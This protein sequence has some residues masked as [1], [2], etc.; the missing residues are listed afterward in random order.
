MHQRLL[1]LSSLVLILASCQ[2]ELDVPDIFK[3]P[4]ITA[5][6]Q[7]ETRTVLSV[8]EYGA[9]TIYWKPS[10]KIDVFIGDTKL[11]YTS[12][13]SSNAATAT[14]K[15]ND[16]MGYNHPETDPIVAVYPSY[17]DSYYNQD[18]A[19][20]TSLPTTQYGVPGT[21]DD[22]LYIAVATGT[23][24]NLGSNTPLSFHN[25]CSGLKFSL[26]RDDITCV[27]LRGTDYSSG[28][29]V[30][31]AGDVWLDSDGSLIG[32][33]ETT[34]SI[35]PKTGDTF[36]KDANYYI[37]CLPATLLDFYV[38]FETVSGS[39]ATLRGSDYN[40]AR[41]SDYVD[42]PF[43]FRPSVFM[44]K[45]HI[46]EYA[47]FSDEDVPHTV[48]KYWTTGN[49]API[50]QNAPEG[51]WN[52]WFGADS[53]D[54]A[55]SY[56][57]DGGY[58]EIRF[59]SPVTCVAANMFKNSN[60][61]RIY[62]PNSVTEIGD[63]AFDGCKQL[64]YLPVPKSMATIGSWAFHDCS[65]L[66]SS[67]FYLS[68]EVT[69]IGSGAFWG[70]SSLT[71]FRLP[72]SVTSVGD[73]LFTACSKLTTIIVA[74]GNPVYDSRDNCNAI[75]ETSSD[76]L[77]AGCKGTIIPNSVKTIGQSAFA[78]CYG[79]ST[80]MIPTSVTEI[81]PN[82][83]NSCINFTSI[84]IPGSVKLIDVGAFA[85]CRSLTS[86][87]IPSSV[88]SIGF[89]AFGECT[90]LTSI[91]LYSPTPP[92]ME[93]GAFDNTNDCPIYVP[94]GSVDA[95]K[96]AWSKY[97]DRIQPN[98]HPV[99]LGLSVQWAPYN[100]GA[101][102][103]EEY[104]DYFAWGETSPKSRYDWS[105]YR[106][107]DGS[108]GTMTKYN[109]RESYGFVDHKTVL[110]LADDAAHV[111][112]GDKWRMPT[113]DEID[114]L[115]NGSTW[116][117][118]TQ[119]GENGFLVTSK[120]NGNSIFLPAA[121]YYRNSNLREPGSA[122]RIYSSEVPY[123]LGYDSESPFGASFGCV[124]GFS[125]RPVYGDFV[126]VKSVSLNKSSISLSVGQTEV[127]FATVSPSNASVKYVTWATSNP[128]VASLSIGGSVTAVS[129]GSATITAWASDGEHSATCTV[130]VSQLHEAVDLGLSVKWAACNVGASSPE[131][132]GDYF[133]WGET[134]S[135]SNY[136][137]STYKW[138][139]GSDNTLTKYC[140]LSSYGYNGFID[141]L[142]FLELGDDAAHVNWGD[143]WRMPTDAEWTEL[144]T[145]CTWTWTTQNGVNGYRV[146]S[147]K[148]G[149]TEKSIFLPAAG[150]SLSAGGGT[151]GGYW[152]SSIPD[153]NPSS[154]FYT[155][156]ESGYFDY[157]SSD[158]CYGLSIRPVTE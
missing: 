113:M 21:F 138:C 42:G 26:S 137:W 8:D 84:L 71:S 131:E 19:I 75:I 39:S 36:Q 87:E 114:E 65:S 95:Y 34:I 145:N 61:S 101:S 50:W 108:E 59:K 150:W 121:G 152:A 153:Y 129:A 7:T 94:A 9:G 29:P 100:V 48:I 51:D 135:K 90:G 156:F 18:G 57:S 33:T 93:F 43:Y 64:S 104:G 141:Y 49:P 81:G 157:S 63:Y 4:D 17:E 72:S 109:T 30:L 116:T 158:R 105:T 85:F 5:D 106:W 1:Y 127:L 22:D 132:Y 117:W 110:D 112:W 35:Y 16:S 31:L 149:Y 74:P 77:V 66:I 120:S 102:T 79:L 23:K 144:R 2:R 10:D 45:T 62:L 76:E 6:I 119:G 15:T 78:H 140:N 37:V 128:A 155:H 154:A 146:T 55:F 54:H 38:E 14:F 86:V 151:Y 134:E 96:T 111:N 97:A 12:Q 41:V 143:N 83:F 52:S 56:D 91:T 88:T 20:I 92:S 82:A 11:V 123:G 68:D 103:P 126:F 142:S 139:N 58:G 133:A 69:S 99:D 70:C 67:T 80:I 147:N 130:T 3:A 125:I 60:L 40:R 53:F 44:R 28:N 47:K 115:L 122:G 118:T 32:G 13:N 46:D 98:V 89:G 24:G 136:A 73:G 27:R 124:E 148:T 25:I 107:C